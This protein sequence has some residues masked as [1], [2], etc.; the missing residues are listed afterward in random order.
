M[1]ADFFVR[2]YSLPDLTRVLEA[3]GFR[4]LFAHGGIGFEEPI[5]EANDLIVGVTRG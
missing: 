3:V 2:Y 5:P 1:A 4:P